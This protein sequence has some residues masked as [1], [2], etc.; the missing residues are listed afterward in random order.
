MIGRYKNQYTQDYY[1]D[2]W[3]L[4]IQLYGI[5]MKIYIKKLN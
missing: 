4:T 1:K 5:N 2:Y 3:L